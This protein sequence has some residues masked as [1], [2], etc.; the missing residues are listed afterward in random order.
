MLQFRLHALF[1]VILLAAVFLGI[2]QTAG[3][4]VAA[5]I[6]LTTSVLV[7]AILWRRR[8]RLIYLRIG[9]AVFALVATWFFAV[10][11]SWFVAYCPDCG[12]YRN[13]AHYRVIGIPVHTQII[14]WHSETERILDDLGVPCTHSNWDRWH[15]HRRWGLVFLAWPNINGTLLIDGDDD[16]TEEM[17]SK[18]RHWGAENPQQATQLH[19]LVIRQ[20]K[21][22]A[23]WKKVEGLTA[24]RPNNADSP[25]TPL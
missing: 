18:L 24:D 17:A 10:D 15:K 8:G 6:L 13:F 4:L 16:Y 25:A 9:T 21:Y 5:G 7:R 1:V 11:W 19:D 20:H 2:A 14:S 3:Y 23:F 22:P 12:C